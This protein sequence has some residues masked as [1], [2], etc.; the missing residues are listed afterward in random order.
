MV[1]AVMVAVMTAWAMLAIY[2]SDIL[3]ETLRACCAGLFGLATV[4]GFIALP[5]RRRTLACF[6]AVFVLLVI[7]WS[8]IKPSNNRD[9]QTDVAVL[10]YATM[11]GNLVTIHNI[12]NFNYRT[13]T[14]FD[15]RYYDK[16]FDISKLTSVDLITVYWMGDAIA[17]VM[18]SFG[19]GGSDFVTFSIE[20]RKEKGQTYSSLLGFFK[21]YGLICVVGDERD[22]IRVRTSYRNPQED[23]YLYR[24][25]VSPERARQ[26]FMEY[27]K[28]IDDLREAPEFYNT[29]TTNCTTGIITLIRTFSGDV[30]Y[31]WKILLSGYAAEYA[32][33]LG[34]LNSS[35]PFAE[36]RKRSY[37]NKRAHEAGNDP[38]FSLKI[39]TGLPLP[40]L[41]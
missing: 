32:Y 2:Y 3:K 17:H 8:S 13:E 1:L 28:M 27:V 40:D 6:I 35:M 30:S 20:T 36:L 4:C 31:S 38:S 18:I 7:W 21:Q 25:R 33:E 22:L 11:Q 5:N 24:I 37:I 41:Q 19:F 39:R 23:V 14:D 29:L 9:W 12:R 26:F 34:R 15:A 10:P 16:T